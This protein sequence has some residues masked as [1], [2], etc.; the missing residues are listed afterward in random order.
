MAQTWCPYGRGYPVLFKILLLR[1][2]ILKQGDSGRYKIPQ[3]SPAVIKL[4]GQFI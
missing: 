3:Y 4:A 1:I 2:L